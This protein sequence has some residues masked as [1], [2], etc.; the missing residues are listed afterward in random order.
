MAHDFAAVMQTTW[1]TNLQMHLRKDFV[2]EKISNTKFDGSFVGTDTIKFPRQAKITIGTLTSFR[3]TITK[4]DITTTGENF[5][6]DQYRFFAFDISLEEDIETYI[7]PKSQAYVDAKEGFANEFDKAILGHYVD[8][9]YNIDDGDMETASNSGAGNPIQ[10]SK[11]NIYDMFTAV[12]E[13]MDIAYIPQNDRWIM[14]S[15]KEKRLLK[16]SSEMQK[17]TVE[18]ERRVLKGVIG[19]LDDL[20]IYYSNNLIEAAGTRHALAGQGKPVCFASNVKPSIYVSSIKENLTNF[21][22]LVKGATKF[23]TKVFTEG[24]ERLLDVNIAV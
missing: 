24:S 23:G 4:Q 15:P 18:S 13:T 20:M 16:H 1:T 12:S 5:S 6:L 14:I 17:S 3:Q 7:D 9:G 21:T 10:V 8:A 22:Y 11:T 19:M 2:G